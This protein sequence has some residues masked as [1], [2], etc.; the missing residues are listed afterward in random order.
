MYRTDKQ[1][2]KN[3]ATTG[4]RVYV[5]AL[6]KTTVADDLEN[7]FKK[8]G[9]ITGMSV[10]TGFAFI[11]F[12]ADAEAQSAIREENGTF[13][14]GR[15]IIVKQAL[16]KSKPGGPPQKGPHGGPSGPQRGPPKMEHS[17]RQGNQS[18]NI[19]HKTPPPPLQNEPKEEL[20]FQPPERDSDFQDDNFDDDRPNIRPPPGS[21][22]FNDDRGRRGGRKHGGPLGGRG[23]GPRGKSNERDRFDRDRE[24]DSFRF[25]PPPPDVHREPFYNRDNYG[26][27]Q[28]VEPFAQPVVDAPLPVPDKNDCEIIVVAKALTYVYIVIL[29]FLFHFL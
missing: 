21:G 8:H 5:G 27:P 2:M 13:L 22:K 18:Q 7:L 19:P 20:S 11:Q 14:N 1:F 23:G 4:A 26:P 24:R 6:S 25:E 15:K 10:N 17:P 29:I 9:N 28:R 12:E 3:P 16:D